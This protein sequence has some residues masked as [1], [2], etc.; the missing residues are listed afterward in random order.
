MIIKNLKI[1]R[2][3]VSKKDFT[4]ILTFFRITNGW[5]IGSNGR[6]S[7]AAP[8]E[9]L[10]GLDIAVPAEKFL[11][12][13]DACGDSAKFKVT[14]TNRLSITSGKFR[15]LI[16]LG[17]PTIYPMPQMTGTPV[18][19]PDLLTQLKKVSKYIGEDISRPWACG[20]LFKEDHIYATNNV[21]L[22]RLPSPWKGASLNLPSYTIDELLRINKEPEQ[23]LLNP[24]TITFKLK[25]DI[26]IQSNMLD[27]GWPDLDRF[28]DSYNFSQLDPV[29]PGLKQDIEKIIPFCGNP[30]FP[31][32][33]LSEEG[34]HT[35]AD[36]TE[37]AIEG[38][39]FP[40]A[41][42]RAEPLILAL[43]D[44]QRIDFSL[45]PKPCPFSGAG[46]LE[47]VIIGIRE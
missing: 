33:Y 11:K 19:S 2:G 20:C 45:W 18:D 8:C 23:I 28:F 30:K 43:S 7:I 4:P 22:V 10:G 12:A 15:A 16:P 42:F 6:I 9:E 24:S 27:L 36:S 39:S 25:D 46:D 31:K 38:Y 41:S 14:D 17:D 35:E 37:A 34:I 21:T 13:I 26:W 47:G 5:I 3:A 32:I 44:A 40:H 1:V 29:L